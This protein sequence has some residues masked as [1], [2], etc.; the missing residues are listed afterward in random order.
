MLEPHRRPPLV[1]VVI[2]CYGQADL[3]PEA[4]ASVA[5]QTTPDWELVIVDDGSPD[6]T[7]DTARHLAAQDGRIQLLHQSHQGVSAARNAGVRA[8]TGKYVLPLDADD[9]IAPD[10]LAATTALLEVEPDVAIAYTDYRR[11][12]E[13]TEVVHVPEFDPDRLCFRNFMPTTALL[14]RLAFDAVGGYSTDMVHGYEDWDLWLGFAE[15]GFQAARIQRV[16]YEYR[17]RTG[18]RSQGAELAHR[19]LIEQMRRN[20]PGFFTPT[21][22]A[23]GFVKRVPGAIRLRLDRVEQRLRH[24]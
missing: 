10:M 5:A 13:Q 19:A 12:G 14:R 24:E 7:A 15:R 22:R 4:V 11:F 17:V 21:R 18:T 20:H 9:R 2:P 3:L 8:G 23:R 1:S 6:D 16:L